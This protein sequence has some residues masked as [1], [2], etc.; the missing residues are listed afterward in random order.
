MFSFGLH[1]L[2]LENQF[3]APTIAVRESL[4]KS[5]ARSFNLKTKVATHD[6]RESSVLNFGRIW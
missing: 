1:K 3:H 5:I 6:D 4:G 2:E